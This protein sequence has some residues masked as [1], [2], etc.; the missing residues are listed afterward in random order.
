MQQ[1]ADVIL[2]RLKRDVLAFDRALDK[3]HLAK[4]SL[5]EASGLLERVDDFQSRVSR[6]Q[7]SSAADFGLSRDTQL[8]IAAGCRVSADLS[9]QVLS[10]IID[11]LQDK[12]H[13]I[14]FL[15]QEL[16]HKIRGQHQANQLVT[17]VQRQ[18][19]FNSRLGEAVGLG[20][21]L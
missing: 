14:D 2:D 15:H 18:R 20:M 7:E 17:R 3:R 16:R 21:I 9:E 10:R 5:D 1:S 19:A 12:Q 6:L 13:S 4:L 11:I 8:L